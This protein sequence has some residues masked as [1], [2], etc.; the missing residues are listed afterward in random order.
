MPTDRYGIAYSRPRYRLRSGLNR[1][2]RKINKSK[3][4]KSKQMKGS[5]INPNRIIQLR[6]RLPLGNKFKT[7]LRYHAFGKDIQ[8]SL[9]VLQAQYWKANGLFDPDQAAG[10]HQ[11]LG[12]DNLKTMYNHWVVTGCTCTIE[13]HYGSDTGGV[14]ALAV[15]ENTSALQNTVGTTIENGSC[16]W[17][18]LIPNNGGGQYQKGSLSLSVNPNK[19][20]G[21]YHPLS[22]DQVKGTETADPSNLCYFSVQVQG[23]TSTDIILDYNITLDYQVVFIEQK[24]LLQN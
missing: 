14:L 7:N 11:P 21:V 20:L 1:P 19:F 15:T 3:Y 24:T 17:V 8:S 23:N 2:R 5:I 22:D 6:P 4:R 18:K 9:G 13:F 10:G 12:F 16:R